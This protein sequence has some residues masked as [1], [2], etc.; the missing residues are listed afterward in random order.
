MF[1][2]KTKRLVVRYLR[3]SD[4]HTWKQAHLSVHAS[5]NKW[6]VFN[7]KEKDLTQ[8]KFKK[9]LAKQKHQRDKEKIFAFNVF[10]TKTKKLIGSVLL[11][12]VIATRTC[13]AE[14]GYQ[15]F[16]NHW[17]KGY[18]K[19]AMGALLDIA[20][21][22]FKLHRVEAF[23]DPSNR[24]SIMFARTLGLRKEGLRKKMF[25]VKKK[26]ID[27]TVYAATCDELGYKWR[28]RV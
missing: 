10:E 11:I 22:D 18:A 9:F 1:K 24:R 23:I 15:I 6:D 12:N 25:L 3:A 14:I 4:Y 27:V 5:K 8:A 13:T 21:K 2:R 7:R 28:G 19:E 16:N 26:W 17:G 20:F